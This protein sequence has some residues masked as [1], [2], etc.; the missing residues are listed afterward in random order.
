MYCHILVLLLS[1]FLLPSSCRI[2][3][4]TPIEDVG[5]NSSFVTL[6]QFASSDYSS[7][8]RIVLSVEPGSHILDTEIFIYNISEFRMMHSENEDT[9]ITLLCENHSRFRVIDVH[10]V[11]IT[12]LAFIGC[13]VNVFS[14]IDELYIENTTFIGS[15]ESTSALLLYGTTS[16]YLNRTAFISNKQ[17]SYLPGDLEYFKSGGALVVS[18]DSYLYA[19]N[20]TFM[21]NS[22][23]IGG[24]IFAKVGSSIELSKCLF[25]RNQAVYYGSVI[26]AIG[27]RIVIDASEFFEN[28]KIARSRSIVLISSWA[29]ISETNFTYN[30]EAIIV[31]STVLTISECHF[32]HNKVAQN[33]NSIGIPNVDYGA[34]VVVAN[35]KTVMTSCQFGVNEASIA[36]AIIVFSNSEA[37]ISTTLLENNTAY[38]GIVVMIESDITFM[39]TTEVRSNLGSFIGLRSKIEFTGFTSFYNNTSST[40]YI[41]D[42]RGGALSAYFGEL[43]FTGQSSSVELTHNYASSGGALLAVESFVYISSKMN[44]SNNVV[45]EVGGGIFAFQSNLFV[46]SDVTISDNQAIYGGAIYAVSS[47]FM[48][49]SSET[50]GYHCVNIKNNSAIYGG[51]LYLTSYSRLD[52]LQ[53]SQ[54]YHNIT[55]SLTS[56][57]AMYGGAVYVDD[58]RNPDM[59]LAD[60]SSSSQCPLQVVDLYGELGTLDLK[61]SSNIATVSG[62][63]MYGGLYDR[64]IITPLTRSSFFNTDLGPLLAGLRGIMYLTN[65]SNLQDIDLL[66]SLP[67]RVCYCSNNQP[68]CDNDTLTIPSQKGSN[69]TVSVLALDQVGHPLNAT[70]FLE[71]ES[72]TGGLGDGQH[73][74]KI[75]DQ[76]T[77][78]SLSVTSLANEET[79]VFYADGPCGQAKPSVVKLE[80]VFTECNCPIGFDVD[81]QEPS[82][83]KCTCSEAL[84]GLIQNCTTEFNTSLL[85]KSDNSWI[86]YNEELGYMYSF[87][88]PYGYCLPFDTVEI[89]LNIPNGA[90][91][92]CANN[93]GGKL[94]G[95]CK[96]DYSLSAGQTGCIECGYLWPVNVIL[97]FI[98]N[99]ISGILLIAI[100]MCLNLTVTMGTINGFIFSA[101]ILKAIFPLPSLPATYIISIFNLELSLNICFYDGYDTYMKQWHELGYPILLIILVL[102]VIITSHCSSKF[103]KIIGKRN[104]VETLATLIFLSYAKLLLFTISALSFG[105]IVYQNGDSEQVWLPDANI[106]Y[107]SLKHMIMFIVAVMVLF[108]VLLYTL[109]LLFWHWLLKCPNWKVFAIIKNTKFQSFIEMYHVPNNTRHRYWTGLLLLIRLIIY[110]ITATTTHYESY[111]KHFA[112]ISLLSALFVIKSFSVRVYRNWPIEA[113]ESVLIVNTII[114]TTVSSFASNTSHLSTGFIYAVT[115]MSTIVMI[116]LFVGVIAYHV[117]IYVLTP[118]YNISTILTKAKNKLQRDKKKSEIDSQPQ[119]VVQ[120]LKDVPFTFNMRDRNKSIFEIMGP[121]KD[122]DY[123]N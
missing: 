68:K 39:K 40:R 35:S 29:M 120:N 52:I 49:T 69:I 36:G 45:E 24:A 115:Y 110:I 102:I 8:S 53:L 77:N 114:L 83:C 75:S 19:Y 55:I 12:G 62:S 34:I 112:I 57:N 42:V 14:D 79:V 91:V 87:R 28:G 1:S 56:N 103:A 50:S 38:E 92:Q 15:E 32:H 80:I 119:T 73:L 99:I 31:F 18:S 82:T 96:T 48:V 109:L 20:S 111:V 44:I 88:C 30:S 113:L 93:R 16:A 11:S 17:G 23:E 81:Y 3:S 70:I 85:R 7:L 101:N 107:F 64:C 65:I 76:C 33:L 106:Q 4:I 37:N 118:K 123:E 86:D 25:I 27:A 74:Q 105:E 98:A 67:V 58:E 9:E 63:V 61:F 66:T 41:D 46:E 6:N 22:A 26:Y 94:C 71:L 116:S 104:P 59:C 72:T 78:L 47:S 43:Y 89:N 5:T 90:D 54:R 10:H 95:S 100:L 21:N 117:H 13:G 2:Y 108:L 60:H 121:P 51:G 97:L 122:G 84:S